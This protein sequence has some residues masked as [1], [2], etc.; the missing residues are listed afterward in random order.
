MAQ[1]VKGRALLN[2]GQFAAAAAAVAGVPTDFTYLITHSANTVVNELW[3]INV[4]Q[5]RYVVADRDGGNGLPFVSAHD[6]RVTTEGSGLSFDSQTPFVGQTIYGQFDAVPIASGIEARLI[7]AEAALRAGDAGTWLARL[8]AA[9][10]TRGDLTPLDDPGDATART[11][12]MFRER[13]FWMFGTGHR[14]GDL[15][16]LIRQYGR[17]AET[18]FPTGAYPKGGN[19]STDVNIPLSADEANNPQFVGCTDRNA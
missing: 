18:I 19:Y 7:E 13:A 1:V 10:A 17:A 14:L 2:R 16:R 12:L 5:K 15:R 9:R 6:P 8:N 11:E 3:S 4:G